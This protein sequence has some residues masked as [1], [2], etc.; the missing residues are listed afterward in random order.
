METKSDLIIRQSYHGKGG[1]EGYRFEVFDSCY[2]SLGWVHDFPI[3]HERC[4]FKIGD[5][6]YRS[7]YVEEDNTAKGEKY[8]INYI[9]LAEYEPIIQYIELPITNSRKH[10]IKH[11]GGVARLSDYKGVDIE[12]LDHQTLSNRNV[13][14]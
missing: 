8:E 6:L 11:R 7:Q 13:W 4:T 3:N 12:W 14:L 5:K 2:Q 9:H 1:K 10:T